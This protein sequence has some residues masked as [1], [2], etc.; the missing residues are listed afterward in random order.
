MHRHDMAD[1]RDHRQTGVTQF[2]L[3]RLGTLEDRCSACAVL[4]DMAHTRQGGRNRGRRQRGGENEAR[5]RGA[6]EIDDLAIGSDVAAMAAKALGQRALDDINT[7][8]H[9]V[10][11]RHATTLGAIHANR[12]HLVQIGQRAVFFGDVADAANVGDIGIHRIHTLKHHHFRRIGGGGGEQAFEIGEIVV[13]PDMH[14]RGRALHTGDHRGVVLLVGEDM[15]VRVAAQNGGQRGFV[16]NIARG[17]QQCGRFAVQAGQFAF[18]RFMQIGGACDIARATSTGAH[19]LGCLHGGVDHHRMHAHRQIIVGRPHRHIVLG[20]AF[21]DGEDRKAA[22]GFA[23]RLEIPVAPFGADAG[24]AVTAG[25]TE[26][27]H[28]VS[29]SG[30]SN[31]HAPCA[32]D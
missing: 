14:G 12:M 11:L 24:K 16:G 6:D 20:L 9:M 31:A 2:G 27:V 21:A 18:Q 19:F 15:P 17:E 29:L 5:G 26:R 22:G 25:G 8:R 13:L 28:L 1:G 32:S 30:R 4:T 3:Q 23:Q 7:M 10:T